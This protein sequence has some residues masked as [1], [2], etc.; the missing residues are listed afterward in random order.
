VPT[1]RAP[2][3]RPAAGSPAERA[4]LALLALPAATLGVFAA[5]A[6][7]RPGD[8][9]A[10]AAI[11]A[12]AALSVLVVIAVRGVAG[13]SF[14]VTCAVA[15]FV[16]APASAALAGLRA[17]ASAGAPP[18][19]VAP[20]TML[21]GSAVAGAVL[22]AAATLAVRRDR[23][24]HVPARITRARALLAPV[25]GLLLVAAALVAAS[26]AGP[27]AGT[28]VLCLLIAAVTGGLA[29]ALAGPAARATANAATAMVGMGILVAGALAGY[30][31]AGAIRVQLAGVTLVG[32]TGA[33]EGHL[34]RIG[35]NTAGSAAGPVTGPE[36]VPQALITAIGWWE[37]AGAAVAVVVVF[38]QCSR[39][40]PASTATRRE[41]RHA[42]QRI[43][44]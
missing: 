24:E 20:G 10:I 26:F 30:L 34:T 12:V 5:A 21:A 28:A 3:D 44:A 17:I 25:A 37:L 15:A 16:I 31:A 6:T 22:G 23:E 13:G 7:F 18:G 42:N 9:I 39:R 41:P 4:S 14:A 8:T 35:I 29:A 19:A 32:A 38:V 40:A 11:C 1:D 36:A 2:A 33:P 43:A 27:F